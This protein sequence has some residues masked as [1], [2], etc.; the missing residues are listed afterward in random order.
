MPLPFPRFR[1][2][3]HILAVLAFI[4]ALLPVVGASHT[5]ACHPHDLE[6]IY[7]LLLLEVQKTLVHP[8]FHGWAIASEPLALQLPYADIPCNW[9]TMLTY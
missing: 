1:R 2:A 6:A 9:K 4:S 8:P 5:C 3:P 7:S